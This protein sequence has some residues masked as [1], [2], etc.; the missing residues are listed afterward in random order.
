MPI[1]LPKD[2]ADAQE[3]IQFRGPQSS[4]THDPT[5]VRFE[6]VHQRG[7]VVHK[8]LPVVDDDAIG[9]ADVP[10]DAVARSVAELLTESNPLVAWGVACETCG[11]VFDSPTAANS[12]QSAHSGPD[13]S[14]GPDDDA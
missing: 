3:Y 8:P 11:Q 12:H 9:G 6:T 4:V 10:D 1:E 14:D 2:D 5:G 13:G 7:A